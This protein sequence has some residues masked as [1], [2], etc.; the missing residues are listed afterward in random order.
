[1]IKNFESKFTGWSFIL[2]AIML[3]AAGVLE[4]VFRQV[5][6]DFWARIAIGWG[7][8]FLWLSWLVLAGREKP[9]M[10]AR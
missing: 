1:M 4:G 2:A 8:G 7:I 5:I 9:A 6:T 3:L 10:G